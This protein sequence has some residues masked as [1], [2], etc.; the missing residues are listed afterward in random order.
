MIDSPLY[1]SL[2]SLVVMAFLVAVVSIGACNKTTPTPPVK[3]GGSETLPPRQISVTWGRL[4]GHK[5]QLEIADTA[6]LRADGLAGRE[7]LDTDCGMIFMY[8]D[9][10]E[11]AYW[12][13]GCVMGLDIAFLDGSAQ[14]IVVYSV[15]PPKSESEEYETYSSGGKARYVVEMKKGWFSE[16]RI[17]RGEKLH[18]SPLLQR[19]ADALAR[20]EGKRQ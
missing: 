8:G 18:F 16:H 9:V 14:L 19:R 17:Q 13:K 2:K 4:A 15:D 6:D 12:M 11:R 20:S 3:H 5:I 7:S 1:R 10:E